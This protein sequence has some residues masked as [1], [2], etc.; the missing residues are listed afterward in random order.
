MQ[1][2]SISRS[3]DQRRNRH[4]DLLG[5]VVASN[6]RRACLFRDRPGQFPPTRKPEIEVSAISR[7]HSRGE[8]VD[9]GNVPEPAATIQR[10]RHEVERPALVAPLR[11]RHRRSRAKPPF[12]NAAATHLSASLAIQPP[13]LFMVVHHALVRQ[14]P[15]QAAITKPATLARTRIRSRIAPSSPCRLQCRAIVRSTSQHIA[16]TPLAHLEQLFEMRH[17][18]S[19]GG[20]RHHFYPVI[21]SSIAFLSVAPASN[22]LSSVF[23]S[24]SC[25][26][27]FASDT[28]SPPTSAFHS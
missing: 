24:S 21:S 12:A 9:H 6:H 1:C 10:V 8:V 20:G 7:T 2:H 15:V 4:A 5:A 16:R 23:S 13:K 17:R 28:Q 27:R 18:F 11:D 26:R 3:F 14:Q 25:R 19:S 22:F